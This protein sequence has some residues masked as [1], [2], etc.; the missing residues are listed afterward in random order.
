MVAEVYEEF[1]MPANYKSIVSVLDE[2]PILQDLQLKLWSW[3]ANYYCC[4][5]GRS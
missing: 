2:S 3:I 5:I 1:E 4:N